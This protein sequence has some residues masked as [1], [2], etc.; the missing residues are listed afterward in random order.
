M[1]YTIKRAR[2][3]DFYKNVQDAD[4]QK[5]LKKVEEERKRAQISGSALDA[6]DPLRDERGYLLSYE[7]PENVRNDGTP[8]SLEEEYQYVRLSVTQKS[9]NTSLFEKYLG[10]KSQFTEFTD[11][12]TIV[13]SETPT[14]EELQRLRD[15]LKDEID[16]QVT[17]NQ[18]LETEIGNLQARIVELND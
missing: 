5:H 10:E 6:T 15:T 12:E 4:E 14:A 7:D 2:K 3:K 8:V 16:A 11:E 1:P 18:D 9:S 17:L 13:E